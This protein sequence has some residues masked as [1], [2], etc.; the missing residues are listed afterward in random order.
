M[1][2]QKEAS[3]MKLQKEASD[4]KWVKMHTRKLALL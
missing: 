1:K 4:M 3:D 2:S